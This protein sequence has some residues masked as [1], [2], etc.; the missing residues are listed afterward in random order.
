MISRIVSKFSHV[1]CNMSLINVDNCY[2]HN[3]CKGIGPC[4]KRNRLNYRASLDMLEGLALMI[5][6]N[7]AINEGNK[8][9]NNVP[10]CIVSFAAKW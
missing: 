1:Q 7:S 5:S 8:P 10:C 6:M 4:F 2:C 3:G 9:D